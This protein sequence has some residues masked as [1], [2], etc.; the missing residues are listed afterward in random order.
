MS[1]CFQSCPGRKLRD[2]APEGNPKAPL[3]IPN[4]TL[5]KCFISAVLFSSTC[6]L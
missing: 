4:W 3:Q 5:L 6:F 2:D 1:G